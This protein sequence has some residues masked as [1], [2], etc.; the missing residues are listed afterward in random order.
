MARKEKFGKFV[1]LEEVETSGLGAEYRAAKLGPGGLDKI[2]VVLRVRPELSAKADMLKSLMDQ[3][4]L[5]LAPEQAAG[6]VGDT[7]SD[8]FAVGALLFQMLSGDA[9][10]QDGREID[11]AK[12][13]SQAKLLNPTSD[14]EA[15]PKPI[16]DILKKA[17]T[18]DP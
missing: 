14:D 8:I 4:A 16:R 3:V 18:A 9:F 17:L 5:Y 15:L 6:G 13:L 10:F 1:L 11:Y 12:R 7:R 2:V